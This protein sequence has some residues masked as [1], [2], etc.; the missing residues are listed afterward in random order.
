MEVIPVHE[1]SLLD[2]KRKEVRDFFVDLFEKPIERFH[3]CSDFDK[4]R[5]CLKS[6]I[7]EEAA[8][9]QVWKR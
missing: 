2:E 4:P 9:H 6:S 8:K 1:S 5:H 7:Y 3:D